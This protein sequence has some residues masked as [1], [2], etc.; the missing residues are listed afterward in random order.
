[1]NPARPLHNDVDATFD[2]ATS[3]EV[4]PQLIEFANDDLSENDC[5]MSD[6]ECCTESSVYASS[7]I[8]F[9]KDE[10]L[11]NATI[12]PS[13]ES[14]PYSMFT[15]RPRLIELCA[16][17]AGLSAACERHG[18]EA[19]AIDWAR[20]RFRA[21]H[22]ITSVDLSTDECLDII[23][24]AL[25]P[26][27]VVC[28]FA[29]VP[30]GTSARS[31]EIPFTA[32]M[33]ARYHGPPP[34]QLRTAAEPYGRTDIALTASE[35]LKLFMANSVYRNVACILMEAKR[36]SIKIV[37]ENPWRSWLWWIDVFA[38][39]LSVGCFD[40]EFSN[41][42][43]GGERPKIT[44]LRTDLQGLQELAGICPGV[45]AD[46]AH[47]PW[48]FTPQGEFATS[49]EAPYPRLLCHRIAAIVRAYACEVGFVLPPLENLDAANALPQQRSRAVGSANRSSFGK[50]SPPLVSEFCEVVTLK[51]SE[52]DSN[53]HKILR[54]PLKGGDAEK[55]GLP[56]QLVVVGVFRE[57]E[58]FLHQAS[59]VG[60]PVDT[61]CAVQENL[62]SNMRWIVESGPVAVLDFRNAALRKLV[63]MIA[64]NKSKDAA[65][66]DAMP[67]HARNI[68]GCKKLAT[69][70]MLSKSIN[71]PDKT[72]VSEAC[73]GFDITGLAE[74]SG[75]FSKHLQLNTATES[76]LLTAATMSNNAK[77]FA[78]T[79]SSGDVS[80]DKVFWN[81]VKDEIDRKWLSQPMYSLDEVKSFLQSEFVL[82]R[83]FPLMQGT[84]IRGI[85]DLNESNVNLAFGYQDK[86]SFHDVD[87]ISAMIVS[88]LKI[89]ATAT[90][91]RTW[92]GKLSLV[93]R[94]LDLAKAYKQW[95][96]RDSAL[97][98]SVISVWDAEL[99]HPALMVQ[100]TLPFG[101]AAAV[102]HFNRL[103]R[104]MF[105]LLAGLCNLV[106]CNFYDDYP[107][108]EPEFTSKHARMTAETFL[109]LLGWNFSKDPGKALDFAKQFAALGVVFDLSRADEN[110]AFVSNKTSRLETVTAT[111]QA[112][113]K[114][115]YT[116]KHER[117]SLR[118]T[119]QF[120]ERFVFGRIGKL[121]IREVEAG[122][123]PLYGKKLLDDEAVRSF[124]EIIA[125]LK[126]SEPRALRPFNERRPILIFSDGA[127]G[128]VPGCEAAC[129]AI[130][131]DPNDGTSQYFGEP[132]PAELVSEWKSDGASKIIAQAELLPVLISKQIWADRIRG[133]RV[134]F[135]VD[136][137]GAKFSCVNMTSDNRH[138]R[139]ILRA[140][141]HLEIGIQTWTWYSRVPS[142]SN[143]G[144]PASRLL[145]S[146]V[147]NLFKS[148]RVSVSMPS[149]YKA[150]LG[151]SPP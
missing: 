80:V 9:D 64:D 31:R 7:D 46:H 35:L 119:L 110:L 66:L 52:V 72:I 103:S 146:V 17:T 102:L 45:S 19:V 98:T 60:H 105:E 40:V 81:Q 133:N 57:P 13:L 96:I 61:L 126:S 86:L 11:S 88:F 150:Y 62:I 140:L 20:N 73:R 120:L 89:Q 41:C 1:V 42:L 125:W 23:L 112:L 6:I 55:A 58:D 75:Y 33:R 29:G 5:R 27:T 69:L 151:S 54:S 135:F 68:L 36:R 18:V 2:I 79:K 143:P 147:E 91:H 92:K 93:G 111:T 4:S 94:C 70:D 139:H 141:A 129:G 118:G 24:P 34:R 16:G 95:A 67:L 134:L 136:N 59:K 77:L 65:V 32:A 116:L 74:P 104:L 50:K 44:R 15:C 8:E 106:V 51:R 131:F 12:L 26:S 137:E 38:D 149:S 28:V 138:S 108:I 124:L 123:G 148:S 100:Y 144:D 63:K 37:V 117:D 109:A 85:D 76:Q 99:Q 121:L 114:R 47:L 115:G 78:N 84:K 22:A 90:L 25:D 48:G 87:F 142:H 107:C 145:Y 39:L 97:W 132:I 122:A 14:I 53:K 113:V 83:R 30:C 43:H 127:E 49:A 101:A 82:T 71:H 3:V 130:L 128:D 21:Q 10:L 56:S